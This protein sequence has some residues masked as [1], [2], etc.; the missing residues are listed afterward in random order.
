M[1]RSS[2]DSSREASQ[3]GTRSARDAF[4]NRRRNKRCHHLSTSG[5]RRKGLTIGCIGRREVS[6]CRG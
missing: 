5:R 3:T 4:L 1:T 6:L 2:K